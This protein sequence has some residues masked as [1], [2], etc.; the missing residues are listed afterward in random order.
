[1]KKSY[2]LWRER[3]VIEYKIVDFY[4]TDNLVFIN[5]M[6]I[7]FTGSVNYKVGDIIT[8]NIP[9]YLNYN[10]VVMNVMPTSGIRGQRIIIDLYSTD[11]SSPATNT[12]TAKLVY[13]KKPINYNL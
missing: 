6:E 4:E 11:N 2:I 12:G 13:N 9:N 8:I 1:M 5:K 3:E 10:V 7:E